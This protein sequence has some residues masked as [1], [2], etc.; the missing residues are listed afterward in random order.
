[1]EDEDDEAKKA[2]ADDEDN[3]R[4]RSTRTPGQ[5][6]TRA[7]IHRAAREKDKSARSGKYGNIGVNPSPG[8]SRNRQGD[9]GMTVGAM[10]RSAL[11]GGASKS[12][13]RELEVMEENHIT[14]DRDHQRIP[15][16]RLRK[17]S[18]VACGADTTIIYSPSYSPS[19][20]SV[21]LCQLQQGFGLRAPLRGGR[22]GCSK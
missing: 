6:M 8:P 7:Q 9:A 22:G 21:P 17:M 5:T 4:G 10:L 3:G 11:T 18:I 2:A 16:E 19:S 15:P 14:Y 13:Y 1:M 20:P 12:G